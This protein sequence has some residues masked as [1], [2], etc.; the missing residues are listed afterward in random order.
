MAWLRSISAPVPSKTDPE[1]I[2]NQCRSH[3]NTL[4]TNTP[5]Y[6]SYFA[7][8]CPLSWH[9]TDFR[10]DLVNL[11]RRWWIVQLQSWGQCGA[12]GFSLECVKSHVELTFNVFILVFISQ[13]CGGCLGLFET[14]I[15]SFIFDKASRN[16]AGPRQF[17]GPFY[18][19]HL[20]LSMTSFCL[21]V[22]V[23]KLKCVSSQ[24]IVAEVKGSRK[25][26]YDSVHQT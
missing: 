10:A 7:L 9:W 4:I 6:R 26:I 17:P 1:I 18:L 19:G 8:H 3:L 11:S 16:Q 2:W 15:T 24:G 5:G 20:F 23:F 25:T 22:S 13:T 21:S 12:A 14:E